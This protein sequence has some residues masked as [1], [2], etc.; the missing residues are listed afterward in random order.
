MILKENR[1]YLMLLS[2]DSSETVLLH[3]MEITPWTEPDTI[4][5]FDGEY[6]YTLP[7]DMPKG[8]VLTEVER[9][10][11]EVHCYGRTEKWASRDMAAKFYRN[12][13]DNSEGCERERYVSVLF[14]ILDGKTVCEDTPEWLRDDL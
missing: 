8:N 5:A 11:V 12:C 1:E 10:D 4:E 3:T 7:L 13:A 6:F 9:F 14:D 2:P